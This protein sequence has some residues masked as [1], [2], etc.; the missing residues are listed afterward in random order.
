MN[1][2]YQEWPG[3]EGRH[4]LSRS[5]PEF[6][7]FEER[8]SLGTVHPCLAMSMRNPQ[9]PPLPTSQE[10]FVL[11]QNV[12]DLQCECRIMRHRLGLWV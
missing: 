1:V 6:S 8:D 12:L 4:Q 3:H 11:F 7:R 10:T 5:S 9:Q 2:Y